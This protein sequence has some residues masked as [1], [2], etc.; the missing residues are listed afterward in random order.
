MPAGIFICFILG[1]KRSVKHEKKK[2]KRKTMTWFNVFI[3][4][5]KEIGIIQLLF[6]G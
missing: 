6:L 1:S 3:L 2:K 5:C 4:L